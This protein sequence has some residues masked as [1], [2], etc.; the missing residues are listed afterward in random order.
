MVVSIFCGPG[1]R[2]ASTAALGLYSGIRVTDERA[3]VAVFSD[4]PH[5]GFGSRGVPVHPRSQ[6]ASIMSDGIS[7]VDLSDAQRPRSFE[8]LDDFIKP[9]VGR[10]VLWM[11]IIDAAALRSALFVAKL[12]TRPQL[13]M[14]WPTR[15][16]EAPLARK[17][18][19][20]LPILDQE[21]RYAIEL[22]ERYR[23][24]FQPKAGLRNWI[25]GWA[26]VAQPLLALYREVT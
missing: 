20:V 23:P 14:Y 11:P 1:A 2:G 13:R 15:H 8:D 21:S 25:S 16:G 3:P 24:T 6:V 22:D 4:D 7:V 19:F 26:E 12:G 17:N 18:D 9:E 5:P 10:S